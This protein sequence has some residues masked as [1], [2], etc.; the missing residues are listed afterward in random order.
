M[1]FAQ[2]DLD[3]LLAA[4][5]ANGVSRLDVRSNGKHLRLDLPSTAMPPA[6]SDAPSRELR[7]IS[8]KSPGIGRFLPRGEDD[9]L[10]VLEPGVAVTKGD[11]LAY[12]RLGDVRLVVAAPDHGRFHDGAPS[13]GAV[14]GYGDT[15]FTLEPEQ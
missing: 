2:S 3:Q 1:M 7:R 10:P 4:M 15:L 13:P 9:G 6:W 11:I 12:V 5:R 8:V 14:V